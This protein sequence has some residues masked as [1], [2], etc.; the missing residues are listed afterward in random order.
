MQNQINMLKAMLNKGFSPQGLIQQIMRN[1][2][3][4]M[5]GNLLNLAKQ[6]KNEDIE[7][8][9]RNICKGKRN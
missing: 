3:N 9:A 1:N 5:I 6:G 4:P 2:N 8:F 7:N